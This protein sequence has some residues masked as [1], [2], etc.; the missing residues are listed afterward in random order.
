[1]R[2]LILLL[3]LAALVLIPFFLL[4]EG[5]MASF[6]DAGARSWLGAHGPTWGWL[7]GLGLLVADLVLPVP[8]TSVISA[9]GYLYG[10]LGGGAVGAAGSL[11]CGTIA[12]EGCRR[13]GQQAADRLLGAEDRARAARLFAGGTGGWLVALSRWMP[14][15]PEMTSCMAGLTGMPRRRFYTALLCGCLPM[16]LMF[17]AI[18]ASG[19]DRPGL[20]LALSAA[21]PALLYLAAARWLKRG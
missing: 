8:A 21:V 16:A 10:T 14:L 15:L 4:G 3:G 2:L 1:M 11:L 13:F 5:F 19:T 7:A 20:A 12:Y 6:G 9:L 18:G 17:A